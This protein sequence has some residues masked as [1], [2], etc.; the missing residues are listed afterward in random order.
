MFCTAPGLTT[1]SLH[2]RSLYADIHETT[3]NPT[4]PKYC[5][6]PLYLP[7]PPSLT[8]LTYPIVYATLE[9]R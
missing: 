3:N 8:G 2:A 1:T 4:F 7:L 9:T 5:V 6:A